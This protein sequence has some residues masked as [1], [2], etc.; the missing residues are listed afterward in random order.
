M[1]ILHPT[2]TYTSFPLRLPVLNLLEPTLPTHSSYTCSLYMHAHTH[3]YT[4]IQAVCSSC[5]LADKRHSGT[6][7]TLCPLCYEEKEVRILLVVTRRDRVS[8]IHVCVFFLHALPFGIHACEYMTCVHV[9]SLKTTMFLV[10]KYK[11]EMWAQAGT[12]V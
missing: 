8:S 12:R 10:L 7:M 5:T 3:T 9:M 1:T 4:Y 6:A 11:R 2:C